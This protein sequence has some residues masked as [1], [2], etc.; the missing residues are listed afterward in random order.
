MS[1]F[2]TSSQAPKTAATAPQVVLQRDEE[3]VYE[4]IGTEELHINEITLRCGLAMSMV[5]ASLMKLEMKRLIKPLPGKFYV[6]LA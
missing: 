2:P 4:V 6:R 5:S 1:L 3:T